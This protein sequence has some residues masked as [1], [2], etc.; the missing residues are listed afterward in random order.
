MDSGASAAEL[1]WI[2]TQI[3]SLLHT[4]QSSNEICSEGQKGKNSEVCSM[5][6]G[7]YEQHYLQEEIDICVYTPKLEQNLLRMT[8]MGKFQKS[9]DQ[10]QV[11][12]SSPTDHASHC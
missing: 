10:T 2:N 3:Y 1:T 6:T 12:K 4:H 9:P 8:K 7:K 11:I 5:V